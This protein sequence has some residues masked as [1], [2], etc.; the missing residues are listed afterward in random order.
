M[1]GGGIIRTDGTGAFAFGSEVQ[2]LADRAFALGTLASNSGENS[3]LFGLSGINQVINSEPGT[4]KIGGNDASILFTV[5]A[6][7]ERV[8]VATIAPASTFDVRGSLSL[9]ISTVTTSRAFDSADYTILCDATS[10]AVNLSLPSAASTFGRVYNLKKIDASA[11]ACSMSRAGSDTIDGASAKSTIIQ[12]TNIQ[13]QSNGV[14][15]WSVL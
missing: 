11:N 6:P 15:T 2:A 5:S 8:G 3:F 9:N 4:F 14:A 7:L 13:V 12:Y 1:G 10:G